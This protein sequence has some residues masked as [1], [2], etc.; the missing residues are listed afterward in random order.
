M[1]L[2]GVLFSRPKSVQLTLPLPL[3]ETIEEAVANLGGEIGEGGASDP[4]V[5]IG[6]QP[7]NR[8]SQFN[9]RTVFG[10]WRGGIVP[11]HSEIRAVSI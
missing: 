6:I 2:G 8:S 9:V 7:K 11:A 10:G 3:G 1:F 4:L 5:T